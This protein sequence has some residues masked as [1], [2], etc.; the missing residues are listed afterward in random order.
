MVAVIYA[1]GSEPLHNWIISALWLA[2]LGLLSFLMVSTWR[3]PSFKDLSLT[4]PRSPLSIV[5]MGV[6]IYLI[7]N[8][9]QPVLLVL[10]I[11]YVGGGIVIRIGGIVRRR[12][13]PQAAASAG[14]GASSWLRKQRASRVALVGGDTLLAK[15]M[16]ELLEQRQARAAYRTDLGRGGERRHAGRGRRR[17]AG[18]GAADGR[19]PDGIEGGVPGGLGSVQPAGAEAESA[20]RTGADRS[21]RRA[22][23]T[24]ARALAGSFRRAHAFAARARIDSGD[25][26]SGGHRVAMLLAGLS[27]IGAVR[28]SIIHVFEPASE[29]GKKGLDEL[30]QQTVGVLSFQKLKMDVF[31]AQ[32]GFNMLARYGEEALEPLEGVEQRIVRHLASLLALYPAIPMPSLRLIQ[33]PVFHGHSF[34]VWVEFEENPGAVALA[35]GTGRGGL[36]CAHRRSAHQRQH[37][38][39]ERAERGRDRRGSESAARLLDLDGVGQFAAGRRKTPWRWRKVSCDEIGLVV[40]CASCCW[41]PP[42]AITPADTRDLI[43]KTIHT[44][45]I[46]AFT[47]VTTRYKLTDQLPEAIARE[48]ISRTRYRIVTDTKRRGRGSG[49]SGSDLHVVSHHFRS[50]HRPRQRRRSAR[51]HAAEFAWSAPP[52]K[53]CSAGR[54]SKCANATRFRLTQRVFRRERRGAGAR[55]PADG[56]A[57]GVVDSRKLLAAP[58]DAGSI[59]PE[60][61]EERRRLPCICSWG[62][63]RISA[64]AAGG[65]LLEA[66]LGRRL[67][68]AK[69]D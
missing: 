33:A 45:A 23:R 56:A 2:L 62:R 24:A 6:L 36:R 26:A 18:A 46:P 27:K 25:R 59:S 19:E 38:R 13:R 34:S 65:R 32:L 41:L 4:H 39:K 30:R 15:E 5:L 1:A 29:R 17:G 31:D 11:S 40:A 28:R 64:S 57:S 48:F 63:S 12:L 22:R 9:S 14:T 51:D 60:L 55:Q 49:R 50:R 61:A 69:A 47:N 42:A 21:D 52:A 54:T 20:R 68:I 37:R 58:N 8:F 3:Y 66:V 7:W 10:A 53:S 43:P 35:G 16:R 44:I 67:K